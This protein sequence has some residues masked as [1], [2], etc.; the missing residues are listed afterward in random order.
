MFG[1]FGK[2]DSE[3]AIRRHAERVANK[4]AQAPDRWQSIQALRELKSP[5]A[6]AALIARFGFYV[7]PSITD[8][9][10]KSAVFEALV[11]LGPEAVPVVRDYLAS[12]TVI[13][14]GVRVLDRVVAPA[15]V[16]SELLRLLEA[17][18][19]EYSRSPE[20]KV[21]TLGALEDR[22]DP[23][24]AS[25]AARFLED[26][27]EGTRFQALAT[28][29]AQENSESQRDMLSALFLRDDSVRIRARVAR[30]FAERG[31]SLGTDTATLMRVMPP[32]FAVDAAGVPRM[33]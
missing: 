26:V 6:G 11:E 15:D 2:K 9:E 4:R 30:A 10:E 27:H 29:L 1:L 32:D 25:I 14:W 33:R 12:A 31:W 16:V 18:D 21:E 7:E 24:I 20:R 28:I 5:A 23:R 3:S 13:S 19:T 17:F 8:Q 22:R